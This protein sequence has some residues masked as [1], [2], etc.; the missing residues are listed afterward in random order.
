[1]SR[2]LGLNGEESHDK[3]SRLQNFF[4]PGND[5]LGYILILLSV[6]LWLYGK[7]FQ[8]VIVILAI[9]SGF[10]FIIFLLS[11]T[12]LFTKNETDFR[13]PSLKRKFKLWSLFLVI[14]VALLVLST[15]IVLNFAEDFGGEPSSHDSQN[16]ND[17]SF[18]NIEP[19]SY[20]HLTLPTICSV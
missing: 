10:W 2:D 16:Y 3:V 20:T 15:A 18:E 5:L 14:L 1:M 13:K 4:K 19:V 8:P 7:N 17:G 9:F 12:K 6:L 11:R